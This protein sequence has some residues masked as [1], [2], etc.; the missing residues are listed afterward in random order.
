[1]EGDRGRAQGTARARILPCSTLHTGRPTAC[2][3]W[4]AK[5]GWHGRLRSFESILPKPVLERA[6]HVLLF[7]KRARACRA[8][9]V[10][11]LVS[12]AS[13]TPHRVLEEAY[14]RNGAS[15]CPSLCRLRGLD[16]FPQVQ[17]LV[18]DGNGLPSLPD[19]PWVPSM[20]TLWM[21][22]NDVENLD[23]LLH[24]VR[25]CHR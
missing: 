15:C 4:R 20:E 12:T 5:R 1:M 9:L 17:T 18:L 2:R 13:A 24:Q 10:Y 19:C 25:C 6:F 8:V 14:E 22:N 16:A 3:T 11:Q 21:C 7:H 23:E